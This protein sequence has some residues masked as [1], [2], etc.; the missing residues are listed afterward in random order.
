MRHEF[1]L[2]GGL[3][4]ACRFGRGTDGAVPFDGAHNE[5]ALE[6]GDGVADV[7]RQ[8]LV[9]LKSFDHIRW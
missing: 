4:Q 6:I 7:V 2:D 8:T 1:A 9:G 5:R 3:A